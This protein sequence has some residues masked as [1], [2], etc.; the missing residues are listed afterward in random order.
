MALPSQGLSDFIEGLNQA[1]LFL[2]VLPQVILSDN[3][4]AYV[5]KSNRYEPTFTQMC[6]QLG[7]YYQVDLQG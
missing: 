1:L 6:K 2:G 3:L 7:A 4:K 5:S